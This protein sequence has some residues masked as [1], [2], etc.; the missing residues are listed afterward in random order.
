[1]NTTFEVGKIYSTRSICDYDCIFR[2]TVLSRSAKF[3]TVSDPTG[4]KTRRSGVYLYD[5]IE[6][7]MPLGRYSMAP[8]IRAD[9]PQSSKMGR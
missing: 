1:M 8:V 9:K 4:G 3:I 2:F 5:G 6:H 7:S